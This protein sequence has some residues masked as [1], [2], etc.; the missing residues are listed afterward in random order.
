MPSSH[1][2]SKE[3]TDDF[4]REIEELRTL[5]NKRN[6]ELITLNKRFDEQRKELSTK[7]ALL[8]DQEDEIC[9]LKES[10]QKLTEEYHQAQD[11]Q[12]KVYEENQ[13]YMKELE[14]KA[15]E[16]A[17]QADAERAELVSAHK[18]QILVLEDKIRDLTQQLSS[19]DQSHQK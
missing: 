18:E 4:K 3:S 14:V 7:T 15:K 8:K 16:I 5:L 9:V 2:N 17:K 12:M 13:N 1:M 19:T 6:A 10:N 11:D